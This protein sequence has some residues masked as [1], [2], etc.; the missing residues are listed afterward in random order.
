ML[1][2]ISGEPHSLDMH[3]LEKTSAPK[4]RK[5]THKR[6]MTYRGVRLPPVGEGSRFTDEEVIEAVKAA[7]LM[8]PDVFPNKAKA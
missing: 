6:V 8:N 5:L 1:A 7:I 3:D 2:P 4:K